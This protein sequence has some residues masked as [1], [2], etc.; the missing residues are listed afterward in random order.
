M[1]T[2]SRRRLVDELVRDEGLRLKAYRCTGGYMT[3]GVGRNLDMVGISEAEQRSLGITRE[4][5]LRAGI[6]RLQAQTLLINDIE[7]VERELDRNLAWWRDL[8][9]ARQRVLINMCFNLGVRGLLEFRRMLRAAHAG[10]YEV[11]AS[12]MGRSLW[13]RQVGRRCKR[14]Q[15]MMRTG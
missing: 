2:Y 14:L 3:I 5:C 10:H 9:D 8:S 13:A 6:T 4:T 1:S 7:R 11:A 15:A 12:E